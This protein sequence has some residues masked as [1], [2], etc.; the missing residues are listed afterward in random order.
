MPVCCKLHQR[1]SAS[2]IALL[3]NVCY[4]ASNP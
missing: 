3:L 4:L 1:F 2:A